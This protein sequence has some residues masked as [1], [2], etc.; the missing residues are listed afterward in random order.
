MTT[1]NVNPLSKMAKTI[2]ENIKSHWFLRLMLF[3]FLITTIPLIFFGIPF[4]LIGIGLLMAVLYI[5]PIWEPARRLTS[6]IMGVTEEESPLLIK[7][8]LLTP[9]IWFAIRSLPYMALVGFGIWLLI[10][11]GFLELNIIHMLLSH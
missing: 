11:Y 8:S 10:K 7:T 5:S 2:L 1:E 6:K 3:G 9:K 4:S